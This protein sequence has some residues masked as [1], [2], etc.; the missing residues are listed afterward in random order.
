MSKE[1][2][3]LVLVEMMVLYFIFFIL[4]KREEQN[5][6]VK[7]T[8]SIVSHFCLFLLREVRWL[9][10][11]NDMAI[12]VMS[13]ICTLALLKFFK[14][15]L[16]KKDMTIAVY[17]GVFSLI[18]LSLLP[19]EIWK[20]ITRARLHN[21]LSLA[22][23]KQ[24]LRDWLNLV[25]NES[26]PILIE[27]LH[28]IVLDDVMNCSYGFA[29]NN[30]LELC[31]NNHH[32][33]TVDL[34]LNF[35]YTNF[36]NMTALQIAIDHLSRDETTVTIRTLIRNT[37][38]LCSNGFEH[39]HP[40]LLALR[41]GFFQVCILLVDQFSMADLVTSSKKSIQFYVQLACDRDDYDLLDLMLDYYKN[42]KGVINSS[43]INDKNRKRL[44]SSSCCN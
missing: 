28:E 42:D 33:I 22:D 18:C 5:E 11:E 29:C 38:M 23:K 20:A 9:G 21:I 1:E 31:C 36:G 13:C 39:N 16:L 40:F 43:L 6:I 27:I 44:G 14:F 35:Q 17:N 15:V 10:I 7:I 25:A 24:I 8:I 41:R 12:R 32:L 34:L 30:I 19:I 3:G 2:E 37:S 4:I 26:K